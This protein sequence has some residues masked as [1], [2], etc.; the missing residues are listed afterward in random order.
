MLGAEA[1]R[2]PRDLAVTVGERVAQPRWH[3][4]DL[5]VLAVPAGALLD[6]VALPC[7]LLR[8]RRAIERPDLS[9]AAEDRARGDGHDAVVLPDR[10][11]DHDVG[12]Q[13]RV[14]RLNATHSPGCR[15]AVGGGDHV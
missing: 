12:M 14:R 5:E 10:A 6:R 9:D 2:R 11:G 13:L 7:Q 3:P 8:E 15:V 1:L 4:G